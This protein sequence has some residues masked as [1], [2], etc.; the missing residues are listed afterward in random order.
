MLLYSREVVS[1]L[2]EMGISEAA[3]RCAS[4]DEKRIRVALLTGQYEINSERLFNAAESP[5]ERQL[6]LSLMLLH[7][8][9]NPFC[10]VVGERVPKGEPFPRYLAE[11]RQLA[12]RGSGDRYADALIRSALFLTP[13]PEFLFDSKTIRADAVLWQFNE[14]RQPLVVECDGYKWHGNR[15]A[16]SADRARDRLLI[17][18]GYRVV[19]FSGDEIMQDPL[20]CAQHLQAVFFGVGHQPLTPA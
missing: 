4:L 13:Q 10:L 16:F 8:A 19:R 14:L 7:L 1:A 2:V 12:V 6:F 17:S 15:S 5:I 20:Y 3:D 18:A 11:Y 9:H